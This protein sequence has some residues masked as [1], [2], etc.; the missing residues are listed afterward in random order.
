MRQEVNVRE[1]FLCFLQGQLPGRLSGR[2]PGRNR[3]ALPRAQDARKALE[4]SQAPARQ[5][6]GARRWRGPIPG[7]ERRREG[8]GPGRYWARTQIP[9]QGAGRGFFFG[10]FGRARPLRRF[11]STPSNLRGLQVQGTANM[12]PL[13][14]SFPGRDCGAGVLQAKRGRGRP[15][16]TLCRSRARAAASIP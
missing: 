11:P 8:P 7:Q 3:R 6:F 14:S 9:S 10:S 16:P 5:A 2:L 4:G 12:P 13:E 1:G 15:P